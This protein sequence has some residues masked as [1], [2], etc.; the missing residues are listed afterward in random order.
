MQCRPLLT[1]WQVWSCFQVFERRGLLVW[2][3]CH[4]PWHTPAPRLRGLTEGTAGATFVVLFSFPP[5]GTDHCPRFKPKIQK[6][7]VNST[8]PQFFSLWAL[9]PQG[10]SLSITPGGS[11]VSEGLTHLGGLW[12]LTCLSLLQC[13]LFWRIQKPH[14]SPP[15]SQD[16]CP[17]ASPY[18]F[19]G[20][21]L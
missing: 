3:L 17:K 13:L 5:E 20:I 4:S 18:L 14:H 19:P 7:K 10:A 16:L 9:S 2:S 15:P 12:P 6:Q 21:Q 8:A 1:N 11:R